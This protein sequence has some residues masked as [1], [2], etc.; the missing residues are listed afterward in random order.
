MSERINKYDIVKVATANDTNEIKA[1]IVKIQDGEL[2]L[3]V[4][5]KKL[6]VKIGGK[7]YSVQ[8]SEVV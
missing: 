1:N 6:C 8:L 4:V 3:T 5:D 7:I 2:I